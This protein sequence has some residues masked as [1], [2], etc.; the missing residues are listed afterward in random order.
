MIRIHRRLRQEKRRSRLLL[1]IHDELLIEVP[2]DEREALQGL[3]REE[4]EGVTQLAIP[5]KV[6]I[7]IGKNWAEAH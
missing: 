3:V 7:G 5:L 4:M 1:Q 6:E 2:G